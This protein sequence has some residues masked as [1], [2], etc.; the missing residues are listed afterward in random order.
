M[1]QKTPHALGITGFSLPGEIHR[2]PMFRLDVEQQLLAKS[3]AVT[4]DV[5]FYIHFVPGFIPG[6]DFSYGLPKQ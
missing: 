3:L 4:M 1:E 2:N 6:F 5:I